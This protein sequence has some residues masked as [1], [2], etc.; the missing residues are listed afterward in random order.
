MVQDRK[1]NGKAYRVIVEET[2]IAHPEGPLS[3]LF[4]RDDERWLEILK[5]LGGPNESLAEL[6]E[7]L[8]SLAEAPA[9]QST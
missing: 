2:N 1:I 9:V 5:S 4:V 6:A 7:R 8:W 3:A